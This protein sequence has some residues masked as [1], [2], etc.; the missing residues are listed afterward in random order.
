MHWIYKSNVGT[1]WI[2][3]DHN[4][5]FILGINDDALGSYLNP[6]QAADDVYMCATGYWEWDKQLTVNCP[7][8]LSEWICLK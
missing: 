3:P 8:D 6:I 4:N 1:F 5:R 7:T 2:K